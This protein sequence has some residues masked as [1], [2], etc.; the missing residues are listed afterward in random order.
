MNYI[1]DNKYK[2][3]TK[4][5]FH[6]LVSYSIEQ[7]RKARGLNKKIVKPIK[8]RKMP[9]DFCYTFKDQGSEP[10]KNFLD[11]MHLKQIYCGLVHI[12]N[13]DQAYAVF[14]DWGQHMHMEWKTPEEFAEFMHTKEGE[15][16]RNSLQKEQDVVTSTGIFGKVKDIDE[17]S[18][19]IEVAQGMR[20]KVD[21]R[22][23]NPVP[24]PQPVKPEKPSRRSKKDPSKDEKA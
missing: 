6:P 12:D 11:R 20:I 22:Y 4:K 23:V 8:V 15:K 3:L 2:F 5:A 10:I 9:I 18:V 14:Y 21:K 1:L 17:V 16:F 7:I 24:T 13:M 19:T